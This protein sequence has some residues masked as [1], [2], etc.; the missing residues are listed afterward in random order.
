DQNTRHSE[1]AR[2][3]N[4]GHSVKYPAFGDKAAT[5]CPV[6]DGIPGISQSAPEFSQSE[7]SPHP[8]SPFRGGGGEGGGRAIQQQQQEPSEEMKAAKAAWWDNWQRD[9]ARTA[10]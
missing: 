6:F 2:Q 3:E 10:A 8:P 9:K 5:E 1:N 7:G 4:A